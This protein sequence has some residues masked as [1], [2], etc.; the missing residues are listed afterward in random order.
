[1]IR[2][3]LTKLYRLAF[4]LTGSRADAEDLVQDVLVKVFARE[5]LNSV[6]DLGTWL[7]RVLY[8]QFI[9]DRRRYGRMPIRLVDDEQELEVAA[10][11]ADTPEQQAGAA[12]QRNRLNAALAKLSEEQRM[13]VLLHDTEGY[14]LS[15]IETLTAAPIGTLKSRLHRA[16]ARLADLLKKD[17]TF[18]MPP[19]CKSVDGVKTDAL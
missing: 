9:D 14:T 15:E 4:R 18:A 8:N 6:R 11:D 12:E 16:R 19:A 10:G 7:G 1:M 3:H 17:G 2:P 13:V 5:E